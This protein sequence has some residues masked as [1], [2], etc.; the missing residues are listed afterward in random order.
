MKSSTHRNVL[1]AVIGALGL[2]T[3]I[4]ALQIFKYNNT[5]SMQKGIYVRTFGSVKHGSTV[6]L[7]MPMDN[8]SVHSY[9]RKYPNAFTLF[10]Q[11]RYGL[12]KKVVATQGDVFC[13]YKNNKIA[14]ND[15]YVANAKETDQN[16][17]AL[18]K[19]N[20]C[21]ALTDDEIAVMT[22]DPDSFDSRYFSVVEKSKVE[23]YA[24]LIGRP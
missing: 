11:G 5:D 12:L 17:V 9:L 7:R 19:W 20:G 1:V 22:Q 18:P 13:R 21:R 4:S 6:F 3:A 16:G 2:F 23:T 14:I 10:E 15:T 8:E 24:L